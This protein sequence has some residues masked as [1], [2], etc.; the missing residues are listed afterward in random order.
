MERPGLTLVLDSV[1]RGPQPQAHGRV[2]VRTET[3]YI[4]SV[5]A[6]VHYCTVRRKIPVPP[7]WAFF[8]PAKEAAFTIDRYMAIRFEFDSANK[9]LLLRVEGP[10]TDEVLAECYDAVR[11]YSTETD[12]SAGIFDFSSVTEFPV[13]T[14]FIRRLAKREPAMPHATSRPR[15][16]VAPQIHAFGLIRMFQTLGESTRPMLQVAHSMDEAFKLL[17]VP[18]PHFEPLA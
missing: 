1:V 13:S 8:F 5:L 16:L 15:I 17:G 11:R 14:A 2:P 9:I 7:Y 12:A 10:L 18:S 6:A 3:T 4:R